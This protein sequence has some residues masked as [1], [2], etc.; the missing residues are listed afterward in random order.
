MTLPQ[1]L[2]EARDLLHSKK[3]SPS[4]LLKDLV[5]NIEKAEP[6]VKAWK[7][8]QLDKAQQQAKA[9][10]KKLGTLEK[11][12]DLFGIPYGAK[13]IISTKGIPTECGS[14]VLAGHIPDEDATVILKLTSQDAILL[15]KTT[16]TEFA[17]L[18]NPPPTTNAWSE[19]HTPGGSSSGSA[20]AMGARMAYFTLGTQTAGSISRPAA[21]N[22]V[23]ALK[24]TFGRVSKK[25]VF[26][27]GRSL[28]HVGAFTCSVSDSVLVYNAMAGEDPRDESTWYL[29]EKKLMARENSNYT[30][31]ILDDTYF[32]V[33]EDDAKQRLN[34]AIEHLKSL[35]VNIVKVMVPKGFAEAARAQHIVMQSEVAS[36]HEENFKKKA[37]LFHPYLQE[38]IKEGLEIKAAQY[39]AAQEVRN[40]YRI[41]FKQAFESADILVTPTA[42]STAPE[43]CGATGSPIFNLPFTSMGVPTLTVPIGFSAKNGMPLGMQLIAPHLEEQRLVDLGCFY[44]KHTDWHLCK[45]AFLT[46]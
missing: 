25:G 35:G 8:I 24:A 14:K 46:E 36:Y 7:F 26:P 34:E 12:P 29:P 10:D 21:F 15:G 41:A 6:K 19:G 43:G 13:D 44:Q 22:G 33:A 2:T 30:L 9:L 1:T 42:L 18:G 23:S 16:T 5:K 28:D 11:L 38:F 37:E 17:N 39:L 4:E 40:Q 20:A 45:P 31:G 3:I 27:C 32:Y